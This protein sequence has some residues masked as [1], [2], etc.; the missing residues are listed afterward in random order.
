MRTKGYIT[1]F[2]YMGFIPATNNYLLFATENEYYEYLTESR[3]YLNPVANDCLWYFTTKVL[4]HKQSIFS[5][6]NLHI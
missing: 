5:P 6:Q 4:Y 2:G 1:P 3:Q